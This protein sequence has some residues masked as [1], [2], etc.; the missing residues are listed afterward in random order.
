MVNDDWTSLTRH[1]RPPPSLCSYRSCDKK[2]AQTTLFTSQEVKMPERRRRH[3]SMKID[4]NATIANNK[5]RVS[6][7]VA[8]RHFF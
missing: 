5:P 4:E 2:I 7:P 8:T 3:K 1:S 6:T